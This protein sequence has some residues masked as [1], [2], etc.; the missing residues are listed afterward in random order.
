MDQDLEQIS[1]PTP[2]T[3]FLIFNLFGDY[4]MPRGGR[5]WTPDLLYLLDLLGVSERAAR[6]TLSRMKKR[7]WFTTVKDGRQSRYDLTPAGRAICEAGNQRIFE[8]PL[9]NWDGQWHLVVYSLPEE[10]RKI[11]NEV[12]KKLV[13]FGYGNL[14]PGT[15]I[16]PH[17]R[18]KELEPSLIELGVQQYVDLFSGEH[19][20]ITSDEALVRRCWDLEE[21]AA[22]YR[23][24]FEKHRFRY[25]HFCTNWTQKKPTAEETFCYRFWLTYEFQQFPRLDPNLP[26]ELLPD[27][28][29]G[30]KARQM[31]KDCRELLNQ[32]VQPFLD[33]VIGA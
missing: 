32:E 22:A 9:D 18:H 5:I 12:R 11:R 7:G 3:Q 14:A 24:F 25:K 26:M 8:P 30:Y 28:W 19:M 10:M 33:K 17:D 31:F 15:W 1:R 16:A 4:I 20:G 21:I 27:E 23:A 6:S 29:I 13:W 2:S